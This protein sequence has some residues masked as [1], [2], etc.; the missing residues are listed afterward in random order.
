MTTTTTLT[1][2]ERATN[3][4]TMRH[5]L[6]IRALLMEA[7]RELVARADAHDLSKLGPPEVDTFTKYTPVLAGLTYGSDAYKAALKEMEPALVNH[8]QHNRHHPE[9]FPNGVA[10]MDL[11]DVLE[12]LIDWKAA[13]L[14]HRDG[15]IDR[16]VVINATRF[17]MPDALVRLITNTLP[18]LDEMSKRSRVALSYPHLP[19]SAEAAS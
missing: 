17:A 5:I 18:K 2:A 7:I 11:F 15:S 3:A 8:Y 4:E 1:D 10:D 12:M 13:T 14:R 9:F 6:T 16:S 19:A